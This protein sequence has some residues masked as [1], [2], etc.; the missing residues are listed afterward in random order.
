[1][2]K[3][4][5]FFAALFIISA[6]LACI[7]GFYQSDDSFIQDIKDLSPA[8]IG[9]GALFATI[10]YQNKIVKNQIKTTIDKEWVEKIRE[11]LASCIKCANDICE[12]QLQKQSSVTPSQEQRNL[13]IKSKNE[14]LTSRSLLMV[15]L[16]L[17]DYNESGLFVKIENL[18]LEARKGNQNEIGT[19]TVDILAVVQV[20]VKH[21]LN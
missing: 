8:I 3:T 16:N 10:Y 9:L 1:M 6:C 11:Y 12:Y 4:I 19:L 20:I 14:Y 18:Y 15:Y 13:Y 17:T 7:G 2:K 21:K 5:L